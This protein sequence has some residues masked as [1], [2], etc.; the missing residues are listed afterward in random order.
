MQLAADV[1]NAGILMHPAANVAHAG[2]LINPAANVAHASILLMH[3]AVNMANYK[4]IV[5]S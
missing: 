5:L 3:T 4:T 2:I 1:S